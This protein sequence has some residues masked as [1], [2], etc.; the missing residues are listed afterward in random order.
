MRIGTW[1]TFFAGYSIA[2]D[3]TAGFNEIVFL[4]IRVLFRLAVFV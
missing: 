4:S 3:S 1:A 2:T